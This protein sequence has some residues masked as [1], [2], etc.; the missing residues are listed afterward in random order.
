M[1]NGISLSEAL[2]TSGSLHLIIEY[3]IRVE[4]GDLKSKLVD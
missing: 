3:L 1:W 2:D 4:C